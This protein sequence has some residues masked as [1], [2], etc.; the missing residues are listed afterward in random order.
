MVGKIVIFMLAVL[1]S[2]CSGIKHYDKGR[3]LLDSKQL[4]EAK[5]SFDKAIKMNNDNWKYYFY[6]GEVLRCQKLYSKSIP[7]YLK[8][9]ELIDSD[10]YWLYNNLAESYQGVGQHELA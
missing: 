8:A 2:A 5:V 9:F 7:D 4:Q 10:W 1:I 3:A 6:R